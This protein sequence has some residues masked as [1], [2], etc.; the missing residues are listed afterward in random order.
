MLYFLVLETPNFIYHD[1]GSVWKRGSTRVFKKFN[2]FFVKNYFFY[3]L[4][5]F[6]AFI[7][8]I[9]FKK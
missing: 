7:S 2:L 5:R 1:E 8:K 4:D 6:D 3:V 9:I